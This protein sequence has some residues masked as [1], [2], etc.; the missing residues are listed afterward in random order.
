M[1]HRQALPGRKLLPKSGTPSG[2]LNADMQG[3][4]RA[5]GSR[6]RG[7]EYRPAPETPLSHPAPR[8]LSVGTECRVQCLS[9]AAPASFGQESIR[10][11]STVV[12]VLSSPRGD[13]CG[14]QTGLEAHRRPWALGQG[15]P[16]SRLPLGWFQGGREKEFRVGTA[17]WPHLLSVLWEG[18]F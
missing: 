10:H 7:A 6:N 2:L 16:G 4:V 13:G 8:R 9:T 14:T 15:V 12:M 17:S 1:S 3:A 5:T 11:P 18:S